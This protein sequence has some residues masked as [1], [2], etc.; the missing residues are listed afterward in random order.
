[1]HY[2]PKDLKLT[3]LKTVPVGSLVQLVG[4]T[5]DIPYALRI[6]DKATG[7]AARVMIL[8]GSHSFQV[9]DWGDG[10]ALTLPVCAPDELRIRP[11]TSDK[12]GRYTDG[13]TLTLH[14][15]G[16]FITAAPGQG[17]FHGV[18]ID[19]GTWDDS[20]PALRH[21][22]LLAYPEWEFGKVDHRGE[23]A[24]IFPA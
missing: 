19:V 10:N 17:A 14:D 15:G 13:G 23:F 3:P 11:K 20:N 8:G 2:S 22:E 5:D 12:H 1:M 16:A 9:I 18:Q 21:G 4:R 24:P 6:T 7:N